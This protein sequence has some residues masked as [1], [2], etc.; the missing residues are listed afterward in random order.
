[1][2]PFRVHCLTIVY[3]RCL[4]LKFFSSSSTVLQL[5]TRRMPSS[6]DGKK[7]RQLFM[8]DALGNIARDSFSEDLCNALIA[9]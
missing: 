1:M 5:S 4:A 8:T 9:A 6:L 7:N 2:M 3:F